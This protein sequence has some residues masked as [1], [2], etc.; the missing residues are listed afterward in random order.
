MTSTYLR[1]PVLTVILPTYNERDRLGEVVGA[2]F[3]VCNR[4]DVVAEVVVVDDNSPDGTGDLAEE[5]GRR[6]PLRVVHRAGK[7]GLGSA[8][9]AGFA[10]AR[11]DTLCVMDADMS[12]P[13]RLIPEMLAVL[14]HTGGDAVIASRYVPGA[15]IENWPLSRLLMSRLA[16]LMARPLVSVRDATS[17]FFLVRRDFARG[18][19]ISAQGFKICLELL[20]RGRATLVAEIPVV[21]TDR[22][23]GESKMSLRE[24]VGYV[25]QLRDLLWFK[26]RQGLSSR[27]RRIVVPPPLPTIA[28]AEALRAPR[29]TT[30]SSH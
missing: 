9:V 18:V 24:G 13:A 8:V 29:A 14:R 27:A 23:A 16:C 7:Q 4:H 17:G 19:H 10:A 25:R 11:G 22:T 6:Y 20:V 1:T 3:D 21:F 28:P 2:V 12:H 15:R 5:L 30:Q 26:A